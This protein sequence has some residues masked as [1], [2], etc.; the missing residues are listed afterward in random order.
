MRDVLEVQLPD[1]GALQAS[2]EDVDVVLVHRTPG[3]AQTD[4]VKLAVPLGQ[5]PGGHELRGVHAAGVPGAER[6]VGPANP[7]AGGRGVWRQGAP[8]GVGDQ[9]GRRQLEQPSPGQ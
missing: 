6:S 5:L 2:V 3:R 8:S 4:G 1:S 7:F 9:R